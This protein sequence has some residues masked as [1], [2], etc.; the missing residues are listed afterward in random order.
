[1]RRAV[2]GLLICLAA[3]APEA[4]IGSSAWT[5]H[6]VERA[7]D[8]AIAAT[9]GATTPSTRA[10]LLLQLSEAWRAATDPVLADRALQQARQV[11]ASPN[12]DMNDFVRS[13][14]IEKL[15]GLGDIAGAEALMIDAA[16]PQTQAMLIG[17]LGAGRARAG[18]ASGAAGDVRKILAL[19][20]SSLGTGDA[21]KSVAIHKVG[22][23]L[24]EAGATDAVLDLVP[25]LPDGSAKVSLSAAAAAALCKQDRGALTRGRAIAGDAA[26]A[27]RDVSADPELPFEKTNMVAKVAV[28][29]ATCEGA[30]QAINFVNA[31]LAPQQVNNALGQASDGLMKEGNTE[32]ARRLAPTP[33]AADAENLMSAAQRALRQ[34]EKDKAQRLALQASEVALKENRDTA[35]QGKWRDH[36]ALL[37]RLFGLLTELGRYDQAIAVIEPNDP[38]NRRQYYVNAVDIAA[39]A[40]ARE[41]VSELLPRTLDAVKEPSADWHSVQQLERLIEFLARAGYV[42]EAKKAFEAWTAVYDT[43]TQLGGLP[44]NPVM[45]AKV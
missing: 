32:L 28:A 31:A 7:A 8:A 39:R 18:D 40:D 5:M 12:D 42:A 6:D 25:S 36:L 14:I 15:A 23:A 34:G 38:I 22:A 37:G 24:I 33:N 41:A 43:L 3:V 1:M 16:K 17:S 13:Q 20:A 45:K 11:L 30:E 27:A 26:A 44:S 29:V 19:P 21:Q 35:L 2:V 9:A 10:M 4:A